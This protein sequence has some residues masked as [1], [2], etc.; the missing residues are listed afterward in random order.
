MASTAIA[1]VGAG[2]QAGG[3]I[4]GLIGSISDAVYRGQELNLSR[5]ALTAQTEFNNNALKLAAASPFIDA[6]AS[7]YG[8]Q[9]MMNAKLTIAQN[10]GANS[11]TLAALAAGQNGVYVNGRYQPI[12]YNNTYGNRSY[13][14]TRPNFGIGSFSMPTTTIS[15]ITNN[16][17]RSGYGYPYAYSGSNSTVSS[18]SVR[19]YTVN[20]SVRSNSST[21]SAMQNYID[22][23]FLQPGGT[24]L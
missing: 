14:Q 12:Q 24:R 15:K 11:S 3:A 8:Y 2:A 22:F 18:G 16:F 9:Q 23:G 6:S 17:G 7:A 4:S 19:S 20:G 1:A 10:L 21:S 13:V 5:D